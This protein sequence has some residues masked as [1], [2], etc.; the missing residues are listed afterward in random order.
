M[1]NIDLEKYHVMKYF[2][3]RVLANGE[4]WAARARQ[5]SLEKLIELSKEDE[6]T[7]APNA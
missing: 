5:F 2:L 6:A 1:R 4:V 3:F 7:N